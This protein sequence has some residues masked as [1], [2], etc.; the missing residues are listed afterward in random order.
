MPHWRDRMREIQ[1]DP[2]LLSEIRKYGRFDVNAC[3]YCGSCSIS[4]PLSK[5]GATFPRRTMVSA[6]L[7]AKSELD[8]SPEPW[9]CYYCGDCATTCPREAEPGESMM[10]LRRYLTARYDWT[11]LYS[12]LFKSKILE[13]AVLFAIGLAVLL[14]QLVYIPSLA[15]LIEIGELFSK[16][17]IASVGLFVFL[18]NAL[19]MY[20]FT[21]NKQ[22]IKVPVL[23]NIKTYISKLWALIPVM[24]QLSWRDCPESKGLSR[25][26]KHFLISSG[27]ALLLTSVVF[28]GWFDTANNYPMYHPLTLLGYFAGG[29]LLIFTAEAL[30]GRIKKGEEMHK[31]SEFGDWLFLTLLFLIALAALITRVLI[32]MGFETGAYYALVSFHVVLLPWALVVVPFG[33]TSHIIYRPI[34]AYLQ[35]VKE[36]LL[37]Q[38]GEAK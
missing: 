9:L 17:A 11:G 23:P 35:A 15:D 18:P 24:L 22:D 4:C 7:G 16:V 19:R 10:T 28:L 33:K 27:W 14:I 2:T 8:G 6:Q 26:L 1:L 29:A 5:D 38:P 31:F 34:A 21:M 12:M 36:S 13:L 37:Q 3:Y 32:S 25:W 20:L 30:I